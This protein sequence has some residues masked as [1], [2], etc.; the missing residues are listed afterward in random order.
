MFRITRPQSF[1]MRM[2]MNRMIYKQF[3]F[4]SIP[5]LTF[6][7]LQMS[8]S[9]KRSMSTTLHSSSS[10]YSNNSSRNIKIKSTVY[11]LGSVII[12]FIGASYLAVPLYQLYVFTYTSVSHTLKR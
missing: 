6:S 9:L 4:K 8:Q 11:Y 7:H 5:H 10:Q 12:V 3:H 2:M 1:M